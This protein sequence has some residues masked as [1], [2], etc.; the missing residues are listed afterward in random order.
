MNRPPTRS[1]SHRRR[2]R[3]PGPPCFGLVRG[4]LATAALFGMLLLASPVELSAQDLA[5]ADSIVRAWVTDGRVPGAVLRVARDGRPL[6]TRAYGLARSHDFGGG[7]Y[8]SGSG[9]VETATPR[10]MTVETVF[11]LASVTKVMATTMALM[12]LVD[13][14]QVDLS[15]P[16]AHYLPGFDG[17]KAGI[18]VEHLLTH[19]SGLAQWRPIYYAATDADGALSYI[20]NLPLSWPVGV[21]RH[22]SD[23]GFMTLGAL[24]ASVSGRSLDVFLAEELYRPLG[25]DAT[26]FRDAGGDAGTS[27][28]FAATSHGNPFEHRMVHE[29]DFGYRIEGDPEAW[30]GWRQRTLSGEV[31]D[32]NAYHAFQG[33]AGHAGLFSTA[34]DLDTLIGLLLNG[35]ESG[36]RRFFGPA[37][38]ERFLRPTGDGQALGWQ[39][40]NYAPE[41]SFAHTGFTGTFVLGVPASGLSVVL[42]TN[43]QNAGVDDETRYRDVGSLQRTVTLALTGGS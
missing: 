14:G 6:L 41:G 42:L 37:V 30:D 1:S 18:T 7:Q 25:L 27:G 43:R 28:P 22:Y 11:D 19:R 38:V 33:V 32:G 23:L 8:P 12:L 16:V 36:G 17:D 39:L 2:H 31:N 26:G 24:V 35:G 40:P 20:A 29:L 4:A 34:S 15:A 9:I 5:Q 21:E 10:L 13:R 3:R